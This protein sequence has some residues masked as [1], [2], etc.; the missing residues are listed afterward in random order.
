MVQ[1]H[2]TRPSS[3]TTPK[4]G[5]EARRRGQVARSAD[6]ASAA[7]LL[8]AVAMMQT[9]GPKLIVSL[10]LLLQQAISQPGVQFT[11]S[12]LSPL[13]RD[14]C[15][16]NRCRCS[17]IVLLAAIVANLLQ[18]GFLFRFRL[19]DEAFDVAKGFERLTSHRSRAK[20]L[21]DLVKLAAV[22]WVAYV[23]IRQGFDR[24]AGLSQLDA[25]SSL[26]AG[27]SIV[28]RYRAADRRVTHLVLGLLDYAY[29]RWQHGCERLR[30]TRRE[31]KDELRQMEGDPQAQRREPPAF[32]SIADILPARTKNRLRLTCW[33]RTRIKLAVA[34]RYDSETMDAPQI[35]AKGAGPVVARL[36]AAAAG[37]GVPIIE[38]EPLARTLSKL[39]DIGIGGEIPQQLYSAVAQILAYA[40]ATKRGGTSS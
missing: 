32:A 2:T 17:A 40:A 14:D 27:M 35:V 28:F 1:R 26:I 25:G 19:N 12:E 34:I 21:L 9:A 15:S 10:R 16:G 38:Q 24:I 7:V 13:R 23:L 36:R 6:L 31:I 8:A 39:I 33:L 20:M 4:R 29:Q 37:G 3:L 11:Q 5:E 30:M 22:G 18:F